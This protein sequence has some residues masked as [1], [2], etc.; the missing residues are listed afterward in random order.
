[1]RGTALAILLSLASCAAADG[2]APASSQVHGWQEASGKY[3]SQAEFAA[4]VAA[5]E[6]RTK[7]AAAGGPID[8]C[9]ADLGLRR[10]Q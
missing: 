1:M 10:V 4:V 2:V 3:P 9:L 8:R 5:C 7:S 6:D